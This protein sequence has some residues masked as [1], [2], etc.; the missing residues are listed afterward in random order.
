MKRWVLSCLLLVSLF[1]GLVT[2][3]VQAKEE[4][5]QK[6]DYIGFYGMDPETFDYLYTYKVIDSQ[7]FANFIDG[8]IEHD[9][10]G[11]LVGAIATDWE[12]RENSTIWRFHL[13][14]GVKW[15]TDGGEEYAEVTAHDFVAGLQ[16]AA[17][18]QSQTLY[19]VQ[20]VIKNLDSYING[21]VSFDEVGVKAIDD[22]TLEYHLNQSTPYF[23]TMTTYSILLPVNQTFL[24]SKG[25][26]CKLGEP[27]YS[28]CQFGVAKPE[29]ILYNGA[30]FL[31]NFTSKSIIEY[32]AN[33]NYWDR[34]SVYIPNVK[35]IYCQQ[36]DPTTLFL[37]F[38]RGEIVSAPLDVNNPPLVK[39]AREKYGDSIFVTDTNGAV[40]FATFVFNRQQYHSPLDSRQDVSPKTDQQK[41]DTKA[42]ILNTSFRRAI[43]RA[44]DT[45]SINMQV[46]GEDLK[47][48][49]LRNTLTQPTF[50]QTSDG[51]D[52]GKLVS[53]SLKGLNPALYPSQMSLED[54]QMAFFNPAQAREQ[55]A[56]AKQELI[57]QGV[58]F[59]I[60]L[61]V[62]INGE[63][64]GSFRSAQALKQSIEQHLEGEVL[65]NLIMSSR[66]NLLASKTAELV[67]TDLV[68]SAGWS[69]DYGDPKS[70]LDILDPDN[71]DLLKSFGLNRSAV[72]SQ[73]E[74]QLKQQIGLYTY[75]ELK[76]RANLEVSD[77]DKR[78][79]LYATAEAYALD[80]AYFIPLYASGGSYAVSR[81]IPYT[82]S[83][84]PYGLSPMKFKRMQLSD[85]IVTLEE[86][87][88]RYEKWV[89]VRQEQLKSKSV[90]GV[91]EN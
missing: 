22:Y 72:Q 12:E 83:Y 69:P 67:N 75:K 24:E 90:N 41:A 37:A 40:A 21:E 74:E 80:Q 82:K 42:A 34:E 18:F 11:N 51:D 33:P 79:Q 4:N 81:I 27:D 55:L 64:D 50:V 48:I 23:P 49:S 46:V 6:Q 87:N 2:N 32:E 20:S 17:D 73:E 52:Y 57:A 78:Y 38:D 3:Q 36:A 85:S 1:L 45:E 77:M 30:Y 88:K 76:E 91:V 7:H 15:Y 56:I 29:S 10:Y 19:L 8:L 59:P 43:M 68:F 39:S 28:S 35:L 5:I 63:S 14:Q 61:D 44:I 71:G 13:R 47:K 54:G 25:V 84:S 31:K 60:Y 53:D 26:G 62:I 66:E 16:H 86:R 65:V 9:S 70:Y 58:T 89:T